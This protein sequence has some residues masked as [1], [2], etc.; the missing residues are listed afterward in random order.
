MITVCFYGGLRKYGR[1]FDLHAAT[2]AEAMRLLR[3]FAL[4]ATVHERL[5]K[6]LDMAYFLRHSAEEIAWHTRALHYRMDS[7]E[8]VVKARLNP[9][10]DGI[11]VMAY[12]M[13]QRDLFASGDAQGNVVERAHARTGGVAEHDAV[14]RDRRLGAGVLA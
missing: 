2:P 4:S 3:F 9:H 11:E 8:P 14:E 10:G 13:D 7:D 12:T 5:W 6:Q 1:R